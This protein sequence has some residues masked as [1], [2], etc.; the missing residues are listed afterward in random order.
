MSMRPEVKAKW[1]EALRSG[2]Y[3]QTTGN[4]KDD[5]GYCCLGVLC[6][7]YRNTKKAKGV[8]WEN[9]YIR[10]KKGELGGG[11]LPFFVMKW[12]GLFSVDPHIRSR[13]RNLSSL[14]DQER[15]SFNEIASL[16]EAEL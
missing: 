9:G 5:V 7:V 14:N 11:F 10:N 8:R 12:A 2:K 16:I 13:S 15:L 3:K 6:D 4:L 1:L